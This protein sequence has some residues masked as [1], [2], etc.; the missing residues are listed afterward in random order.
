[1]CV[2]LRGYLN[3]YMLELLDNVMIIQLIKNMT[4]MD[5]SLKNL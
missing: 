4:Q 5:G 1:M 2:D 3:I